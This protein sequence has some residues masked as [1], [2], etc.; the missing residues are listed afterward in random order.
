MLDGSGCIGAASLAKKKKNSS[1][2]KAS[3]APKPLVGKE[4]ENK[5]GKYDGGV[6]N[7]IDPNKGIE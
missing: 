4:K 7:S 3:Q 5:E 1:T 6:G 2:E